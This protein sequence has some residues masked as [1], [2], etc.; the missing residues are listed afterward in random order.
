MSGRPVLLKSAQRTP[1]AVVAVGII[2]ASAFGHVGEGS[3]FVVMEECISST[4]ETA[5]T[6]LHIESAVLAIGRTAE[7]GKIVEAEV[8]VIGNH[9]IDETIVV[10]VAE[11]GA[12]G[13]SAIG[14]A[15]FG[16]AVGECAVAVVVVENI[17]TETSD[18]EIGSV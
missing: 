10:I 11:C 4:L 8:D 9:Q 3:I 14:H 17:A 6:A 18:V 1:Q 12:G 13:P 2:D 5:R 7:S 16:S 15:G